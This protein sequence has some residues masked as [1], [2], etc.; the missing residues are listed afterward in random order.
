MIG[1]NV[2]QRHTSP[3]RVVLAVLAITAM[4]VAL[5]AADAAPADAKKKH[6]PVKVKL[7]IA[8]KNQAGLLKANRLLVKVTATK[9]TRVRIAAFKGNRAGLFKARSVNF[10][11]NRKVSKSVRLPLTQRGRQALRQCGAQTVRV[12]GTFRK[13]VKK[14]GK[15]RK[16]Q[17]KTQKRKRL[18]RQASRC[19]TPPNPPKPPPPP[20]AKPNPATVAGCDPS[21]TIAVSRPEVCML[22]FPND[23]YTKAA[24]TQTGKQLN[25]QAD[26]MPKNDRGISLWNDAYNRNDGFSPNNNMMVHVPGLH[27]P[28]V[29]QENGIVSQMD[30]GAYAEPDQRVLLIDA[31]SG[32]RVPIWAEIDMAPATP[33]PHDGGSVQGTVSDRMLI[34]HAAQ[35]LDYGKR[36]I[37]ALRN[38]TSGGTAIQPN[39]VFGYYRDGEVTDNQQVEDWRPQME[40][41]FSELALSGV[42]RGSLVQAWDFTVASKDNLTERAT[43]MRDDAFEQLGDADLTDGIIPPGSDSPDLNGI[44][45]IVYEP[46]DADGDPLCHFYGE[47]VNPSS[48][49]GTCTIEPIP[50]R[51]G[52]PRYTC[53]SES[54]YAFKRVTGTITVPCY[55]TKP[56][57]AY[58]FQNPDQNCAPGSRLNYESATDHVPAQAI[59]AGGDPITWEAPFTCIVPRTGA[60]VETMAEGNPG[61]VFGHGLL[62]NHETTELLGLFPAALE[63]VACGTDWIGLS[64]TD[65]HGD[66]IQGADLTSYMLQ[67]IA[68]DAN[69]GHF[70]SLPDRTQQ[71]YVNTLLLGRALAHP[72]GIGA[73]PEMANAVD[74]NPNETSDDLMYYGVSL[75]G[76]NGGATTALA[77][78]WERATLGVPGQAFTT[79]LLR[80]TQFNQFL[81][82]LYAEGAYSEPMSRQLGVGMLQLLWDRG[83]PS[84]YGRAML[85]GSLG[86]PPHRVQIQE[87][88][89]DHQVNNTSTQTL[90]RTLGATLRIPEAGELPIAEGRIDD[91]STIPDPGGDYLFT[92]MDEVTPYW[93]LDT[94]TSAEFNQ[95]GGLPGEPSASMLVVD[96]GPIAFDEDA[97]RFLGTNA[98]PDWNIAPVSATAELENDGYDPHQPG[99]TSSASQQF[100]MPFLQDQGV[101]DPCGAGGPALD[102]LTLPPYSVPYSSTAPIP[103]PAAPIDYLGN[104]K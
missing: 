18:V 16:I 34:I 74:V 44:E 8:T 59:T 58:N 23:Y 4:L 14:K 35:S 36:Y 50:G 49:T 75:G 47:P 9:R 98:N 12:R 60:N 29:F 77:P 95:P 10:R 61:L 85:D 45:E 78:D 91:L 102:D 90:A 40:D 69:L 19:I 52:A 97:N 3:G 33:N 30:I 22:P 24:A 63:G 99:A 43:G 80:S 101:Y 20:P 37:V 5:L 41:I 84:A 103:C 39:E 92:P 82:L 88:F 11:K 6:R 94:A 1:R 104:G 89:G 87:S 13:V 81:P 86:T 28:A 15:T 46:C 62:Q 76:V 26:K 32:E 17:A 79:L 93:G 70:D 42:E 2:I 48:Y 64:A 31:D 51:G 73:L 68:I 38:L 7:D 53:P 21:N 54:R 72:D 66:P 65:L 56:T 83:E 100:L 25:V 71:G 55:M 96:T 27:T 67:M 57:A